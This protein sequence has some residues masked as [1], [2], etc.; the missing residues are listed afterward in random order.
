MRCS[1]PGQSVV[2]TSAPHTRATSVASRADSPKSRKPLQTD[3]QHIDEAQR[4]KSPVHVLPSPILENASSPKVFDAE[5]EAIKTHHGAPDRLADQRMSTPISHVSTITP[6]A[7]TATPK[8]TDDECF[9]SYSSPTPRKGGKNFSRPTIVQEPIPSRLELPIE[10]DDYFEGLDLD[11]PPEL[12]S[13]GHVSTRA[14]IQSPERSQARKANTQSS[15]GIT[16]DTQIQRPTNERQAQQP[17]QYGQM[18]QFSQNTP[19]AYNTPIQPHTQTK[20]RQDQYHIPYPP[21]SPRDTLLAERQTLQNPYPSYSQARISHQQ[22][23]Q[24]QQHY[25]IPPQSVNRQIQEYPEAFALRQFEN[26][27]EYERKQAYQQLSA[28]DLSQQRVQSE[29]QYF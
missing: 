7:N 16:R 25:Y 19:I 26:D 17:Q 13:V 1:T 4:S 12:I 8:R 6:T 10:Q 9:A 14:G 29:K 23:L 28:N 24:S 11:I 22:P 20:P 18:S 27:L 3:M 5:L 2:Q 15:Y 21:F